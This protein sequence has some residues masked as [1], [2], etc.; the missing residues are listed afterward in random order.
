MRTP[1]VYSGNWISFNKCWKFTKGNPAN[2]N[3]VSFDDSSW[4]SVKIPHDWAITGPFDPNGNGGTGKLPWKGEGWYRKAFNVKDDDRGK[5]VYLKF[6]GIMSSPKI[7]VNGKL[8]GEWDYGYSTFYLDV[9]DFVN[10]GE[11][12]TIAVYVD[13]RNHGSRWYPGAGMYRKVEMM[14]TDKVHEEIWGSYITTPVVKEAYAE[15]RVLTNVKNMNSNDKQ[16][17]VVATVIS[18]NGNEIQHFRTKKSTVAANSKREIDSWMTIT[19]PNLWELE[20]PVLYTLKTDVI[21]DGKVVDS[22]ETP[23][24][25]RTFEFTA[26]DGFFLNGKHVQIKGVNLHHDQGPLGS[27]FNKRAMQR[28]I[29]IMKEMG[30]NA[31]RTSHN[32]CAP[33]LVDLCD[34]MGMLVFNEAFDKYD[35]KADITPET[36]F[37][38]FG[39]E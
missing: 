25:F 30:C 27:A 22:N 12:N 6:D 37:Y 31:I 36:D 38:E 32:I 11:E 7:F 3:D 4:E 18:P 29:E 17:S 10:F 19:R 21:V 35:N 34:K 26:D 24:G 20:N 23:F 16:V 8:A 9:T 5:V 14:V 2:A 1:H 15:M 33:E 39:E 28:Q 13:T